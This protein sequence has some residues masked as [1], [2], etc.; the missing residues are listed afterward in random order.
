MDPLTQGVFGSLFAQTHGKSKNLGKAVVIG[1]I[2][3]MAP[4]LDIFIRSAEDPLLAIEY[5]RHFSHSLFFIPFGGLICSL[6]LY[7]TLG[8]YWKLGFKQVFIWCLLAFASHGFV[9]ALTSYGTLL[10]WP[11]SNERIAWDVISIIDPLLTLPLLG[12]VILSTIKKKRRFVFM[13]FLWA[14]LYLTLHYFLIFKEFKTLY[15]YHG[16]VINMRGSLGFHTA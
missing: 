13:A 6:F 12:L 5:H 4:D 7:P 16:L 14:V 3:G 10:L 8:R 2:A 15:L 11:F 9:D 1:G